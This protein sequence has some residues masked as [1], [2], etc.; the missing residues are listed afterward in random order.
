MNAMDARVL[1]LS[2]LAW[3]TDPGSTAETLFTAWRDIERITTRQNILPPGSG[4]QNAH[5]VATILQNATLWYITDELASIVTEAAKTLPMIALQ[6]SD[7]PSTHGWL[8]LEKPRDFQ[9]TDGVLVSTDAILWSVEDVEVRNG[10]RAGDLYSGAVMFEWGL[11]SRIKAGD[12]RDAEF[13]EEVMRD[14]ALVPVTVGTMSYG[15]IP[16][17]PTVLP[18]PLRRGSPAAMRDP[19]VYAVM[20]KHYANQLP[21]GVPPIPEDSEVIERD[22]EASR[23][24]YRTPAGNTILLQ[25]DPAWRFLAALFWLLKDEYPW[26]GRED[27]PVR[28][29]DRRA[30]RFHRLPMHP[31][32]MIYWRRRAKSRETGTGT[33]LSYR[34]LRRGHWRN[35]W[36]PSEGR[37]RP[38]LILPTIVGD[39]SLPYIERAHVNVVNR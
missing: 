21:A 4:S 23:Y 30:L 20:N 6:A 15:R 9:A 39:P 7:F 37:H 13:Y 2:T 16:W 8:V 35:Q 17:V 31:V 26:L 11:T 36:Y 28:K 34:Y 19:S 25:P 32:S 38:K 24:V 18:N 22:D 14:T 12:P 3:L 10:E 5:R 29:S 1:Q 27:F 33:P